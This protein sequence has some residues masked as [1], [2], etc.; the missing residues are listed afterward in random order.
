MKKEKNGIKC[1]TRVPRDTCEQYIYYEQRMFS[2]GTRAPICV[3]NFL[4][5][6]LQLILS[7]TVFKTIMLDTVAHVFNIFLVC[8][9]ALVDAFKSVVS[10]LVGILLAVP[11]DGC[12]AEV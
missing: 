7:D 2:F 9:Y 5:E 10:C 1:Q 8:W 4:I 3:V 6:N 12:F 11:F